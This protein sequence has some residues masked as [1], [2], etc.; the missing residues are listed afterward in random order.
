LRARR[1]DEAPRAQERP[2]QVGRDH[3]GPVVEREV[4]DPRPAGVG[5]GVVHQDR[6]R[7]ERLLRPREQTLDLLLDADVGPH[8]DGGPASLRNL[9]PRLLGVV[10]VDKVIDGDRGAFARESDGAR[11]AD[12]GPGAGD[13]GD[14]PGELRRGVMDRDCIAHDHVLIRSL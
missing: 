13:E 14:V 7:P 3:F 6:H 9:T 5:A 10:F 1:A 4:G 12:A 11:A 8:D 2:G